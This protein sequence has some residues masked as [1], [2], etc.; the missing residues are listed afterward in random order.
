MLNPIALYG[1]QGKVKNG[2]HWM[3]GEWITC[4]SSKKTC[5]AG[6]SSSYQW[7]YR[8]QEMWKDLCNVSDDTQS[9]CTA[10]SKITYPLSQPGW[11]Q[12]ATYKW[13]WTCS[14]DWYIQGTVCFI[15]WSKALF[16]SWWDRFFISFIRHN[17]KKGG[18]V[19]KNQKK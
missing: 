3:A 9:A 17:L 5:G 4:Y 6:G 2:N 10:R 18:F 16:F 15:R 1:Y 11:R 7:Y 13:G 19:L 12:T 8:C 14:F